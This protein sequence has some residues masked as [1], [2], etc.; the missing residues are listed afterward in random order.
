MTAEAIQA[1]VDEQRK[2]FRTE[3]TK[4]MSFRRTMIRKLQSALKERE[5][6]LYDA[7]Y[8]DLGRCECEAFMAEIS[9]VYH[10]IDYTLK[11]MYQ[12]ASPDKIN[13]GLMTFPCRS[14]VHYEPYGVVLILAP[15]NYPVT[16]SLSPLLGALAAGNCA[17][18]KCSKSSPR[19]SK[20]L[21]ELISSAFPK[22]VVC[23]V[24]S[25]S[26]YDS[27]LAPRYDYIFFTGSARVGKIIMAKAA[28]TLTP[29]SL[30]LG[31]K[32]PVIVEKTADLQRAAKKILWAK[33]LNAGQTC[34][35]VDYALVDNQIKK[36]FIDCLT[37][38]I[39]L[40]YSNALESDQY[41][42]IINQ[43]HFERLTALLGT[44]EGVL[45][46]QSDAQS[47]KIAPAIFPD[48][49]YDK[50]VMQAE[51][52]GPLLPVIGY[53]ELDTAVEKLKTLE[54]PLACYI[55]TK[56]RALAQRLI[57]ELAF[58]GGCINEVMRHFD[59][60]LP[61]GG[62]GN[63]GMGSYH[64]KYS[65]QTFSHAKPV[66]ECYSNIDFKMRYAPF[67]DDDLKM[68]KKL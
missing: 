8:D 33:T 3:E 64:G 1:L 63:S 38:E 7:I 20:V 12:W 62:V 59:C 49:D 51:I 31:G 45:G 9:E 21:E 47:R 48:S 58:G 52:F 60:H 66:V 29:V 35:A 28:E 19:T 42:K 44:E 34:I 41:P 14:Y 55:F 26:D 27:V 67:T 24:D 2:Y 17:V 30:E 40:R 22:E 6:D 4:K 61:F 25:D 32:S 68:W 50:P 5:Q 65:F 13:S 46:G 36:D 43:K 56:N 37:A 11:N 16:L 54:K 53:D 57:S 23:C 15:W 18:I 39:E 10:D